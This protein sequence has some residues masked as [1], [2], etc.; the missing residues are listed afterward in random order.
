MSGETALIS[1]SGG[2]RTAVVSGVSLDVI[3]VSGGSGDVLPVVGTALTVTPVVSNI[4]HAVQRK[5]NLIASFAEKPADLWFGDVWPTRADSSFVGYPFM[6][7]VHE[8]TP[9]DTTFEYAALEE[10][11]F[12]FEIYSQTVQLA[13]TIFDRIRFNGSAPDQA[14]GFW[15]AGTVDLPDGY[16]FKSFEP[17]GPFT[18]EVRSGQFSPTGTPIHVLSFRMSLHVQRVTFS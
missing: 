13:L 18:L 10:W 17:V 6:R 4:I 5:Y 7:F 12:L 8:G 16:T 11:P 3:T 9:T 14:A 15:Y 1:W 2:S